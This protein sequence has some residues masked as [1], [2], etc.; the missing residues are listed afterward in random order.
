M[1]LFPESAYQLEL[2][3]MHRVL[4]K[5]DT[6]QLEN[7]EETVR[8]EMHKKEITS[9]VK[10]GMRIAMAVGS[11]GIQNLALIVKTV[12]EELQNMGAMPFI[13]PAMGSHGGAAPSQSLAVI[14]GVWTYT[15]SRSWK[16]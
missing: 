6:T 8:A 13:V 3:K 11:R 5:F 16:Y 2:P 4:Q 12:A 14:S 1:P 9:L 10:P 15:K 7:V